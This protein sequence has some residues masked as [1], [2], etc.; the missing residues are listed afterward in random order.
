MDR[1][2]TK[3]L[4]LF[5]L[6]TT[7]FCWNLTYGQDSWSLD[8]CLKYAWENNLL[9]EA[10]VL[11]KSVTTMDRNEAFQARLPNLTG[12]TNYNYNFGRNVDPTTN[13]FVPQN[14]GFSSINLNTNVLL[15]NGGRLQ[16]RYAQALLLEKEAEALKQ[17]AIQDVELEIA[18][19]YVNILFETEQRNNAEQQLLTS[20]NQLDR[21]Q[22]LIEVEMIPESD[23]FE[24]IAQAAAD[25]Q[26]IMA[27]DNAIENAT[28]QLRNLLNLDPTHPFEV[29]I[30]DVAV[31]ADL[32]V[33]EFSTVYDQVLK[34]RPEVLAFDLSE[35]AAEKRV[36][37][38]QSAKLPS[39][40]FGAALTTNYSTLSKT[41]EN[42]TTQRLSS[43]GIF[44][45]GESV[46]FE[47]E[48][49]IAENSFRTP[50]LDQL[51]QNLGF[52]L[53]VQLNIPIYNRGTFRLGVQRSKND[54]AVTRNLN[55]QNR[56]DLELQIQQILADL[57]GA[58]KQYQAGLKRVEYLQNA[59]ENM[60]QR[61]RLGMSN[62]YDLLDAQTRLSQGINDLTIAKYNLIF[63]QKV[64]DFYLG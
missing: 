19:A 23:Q 50:Y 26:Q 8:D 49:S 34:A 2:H 20:Q 1:K 57:K 18:L 51:N 11:N 36:A 33:Y 61:F 17:Q 14:L 52:A 38:A 22:Q 29:E 21:V 13:D 63:R 15:Y 37:I 35:Q 56:K 44:I 46:S 53:G 31:D 9:I 27:S 16:N 41:F 4:G 12:S 55:D 39:L 64:I 40:F 32:K 3:M 60:N 59:F 47:E 30:P 7:L 43:D 58:Q 5:S 24:W 45:N 28:F 54:L 62:N 48:R 42:F 10:A 6:V 25:E